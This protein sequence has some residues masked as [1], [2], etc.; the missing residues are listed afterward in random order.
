[1]NNGETKLIIKK[2]KEEERK[3][4]IKRQFLILRLLNVNFHMRGI[5]LFR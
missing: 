3:K 2:I 4:E 1:M 5:F